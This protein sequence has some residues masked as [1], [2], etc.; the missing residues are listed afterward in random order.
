[1]EFNADKTEE[2]IFSTKR[3]QPFH[4]KIK[5]RSQIITRKN[6]RKHLGLIL[7]SKLN[8]QSQVREAVIK[9]R[10]GIGAINTSKT[11]I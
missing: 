4:P 2:V 8:F 5:P 3:Q 7:D 1:M 6:E 11:Y 10:R 9:A